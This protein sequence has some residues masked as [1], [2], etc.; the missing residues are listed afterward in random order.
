MRPA[1]ACLVIL[2]LVVIGAFAVAQPAPPAVKVQP[3]P[4]AQSDE[5]LI[6]SVV[7]AAVASGL[8]AQRDGQGVTVV[9]PVI[10]VRVQR[11]GD[12]IERARN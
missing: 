5:D 12:E 2:S 11:Y 1:I 8:S 4:I 7:T 3:L 6:R 9:V 10:V